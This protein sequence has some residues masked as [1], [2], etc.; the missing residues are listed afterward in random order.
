[1]A[2]E[3]QNLINEIEALPVMVQK[4]STKHFD[5]D[6]VFV[7]LLVSILPCV[8]TQ[9]ANIIISIMERNKNIKVKYGGVEIQ[10]LNKKD[11]MELL[12]TIADKKEDQNN[13]VDEESGDMK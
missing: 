2:E 12:N 7:S 11:L 13:K 8:V 6:T 9:I 5:A 10:G 1:M 4:Y 3:N